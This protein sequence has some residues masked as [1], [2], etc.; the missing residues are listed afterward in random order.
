MVSYTM[1]KHIHPYRNSAKNSDII[2]Y[3]RSF[4]L[5]VIRYVWLNIFLFFKGN[6]KKRFPIKC[7]CGKRSW[8]PHLLLVGVRTFDKIPLKYKC[9]NY[10]NDSW[11]LFLQR[12]KGNKNVG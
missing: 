6:F 1:V 11:E 3:K 5:K 7:P 10:H 8:D 12:C 4:Y 2:L 9:G